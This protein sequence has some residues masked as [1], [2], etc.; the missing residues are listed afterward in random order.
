[1]YKFVYYSE[2]MYEAGVVRYFLLGKKDRRRI[3]KLEIL[4]KE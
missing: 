4:K 2:K 1:M 3:C